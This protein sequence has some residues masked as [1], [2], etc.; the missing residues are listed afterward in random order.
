MGREEGRRGGG[1]GGKVR[2]GRGERD[3]E[4]EEGGGNNSTLFRKLMTI[5]FMSGGMHCSTASAYG[6]IYM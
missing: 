2:K 3:D 1:R 6:V 5:S 4:G